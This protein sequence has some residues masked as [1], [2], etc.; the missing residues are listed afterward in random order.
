MEHDFFFRTR[1]VLCERAPFNVATVCIIRAEENKGACSVL[2]WIPASAENR[3]Q[4][5]FQGRAMAEES[6]EG[7][8]KGPQRIRGQSANSDWP[9]SRFCSR[10]KST[11]VGAALYDA[12]ANRS[13]AFFFLTLLF[14]GAL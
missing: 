2:F 11:K 3:E 10:W 12:P 13:E 14:S 7:S 1:F 5:L 4:W 8:L 9:S 6:A